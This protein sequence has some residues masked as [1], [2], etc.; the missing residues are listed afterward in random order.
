[1]STTLVFTKDQS[2]ELTLIIKELNNR[3][4]NYSISFPDDPYSEET[5]FSQMLINA[6]NRRD[7]NKV[8]ELTK[9]LEFDDEDLETAMEYCEKTRNFE[10]AYK[11]L[12]HYNALQEKHD[13]DEMNNLIR[14]CGGVTISP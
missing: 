4:I 6:C 7:H 2:E 8:D 3:G 10:F 13:A 5:S 14:V 11:L 1:M 9:D 12:K